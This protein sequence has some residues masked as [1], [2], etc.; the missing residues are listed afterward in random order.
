MGVG[1]QLYIEH[2]RVVAVRVECGGAHR[3]HVGLPRVGVYDHWPEVESKETLSE[4][5]S[6][7]EEMCMFMCV[8]DA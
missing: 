8:H 4:E 6:A 1:V 5:R 2:G 7:G 3:G